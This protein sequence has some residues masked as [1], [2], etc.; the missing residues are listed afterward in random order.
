IKFNEELKSGIRELEQID[1][2]EERKRRF[3]LRELIMLQKIVVA[4]EAPQM[5]RKAIS[6]FGGH[7]VMEDFL[8]LPRFHRDSM[9]ME[10]WEGPR[11]VLL[12]QIHRDFSRVRDWYSPEEFVKDLLQGA[13][14]DVI[15]PLAKEFTR[16]MKHDS[17]LRNDE[18]TLK[19]CNDWEI[20]ANKL[21]IAYQEQALR[22]MNY[23][24]KSL[25]F[26]KLLRKFKKR[27]NSV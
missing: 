8:S 22:E 12:T 1:D 7:G 16:I 9:I 25:K 14:N 4:D 20:L 3:R 19:I 5:I 6:F 24:G 21:F 10:L 15:E 2:I 11:N 23:T 13:S 26:S 18:K 17:L 27:V